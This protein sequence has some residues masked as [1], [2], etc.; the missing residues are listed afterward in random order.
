MTSNRSSSKFID[1]GMIFGY[2]RRTVWLP[3]LIFLSLFFAMP[4]AL[5]LKIQTSVV[6]ITTQWNALTIYAFE[7]NNALVKFIFV[8]AA[9]VCG[10]VIFSFIHSQKKVDFYH[11]LPISRSKLFVNNYLAGIFNLLLPYLLAVILSLVVLAGNG[12]LSYLDWGIFFA[13]IGIHLLGYLAI[14]SFVVLAAVITGNVVVN[15]LVAG[16]FLG[17]GPLFIGLYTWLMNT[18]YENFYGALFDTEKLLTYVSPLLRYVM[19]DNYQYALDWADALSL[20]VF[21]A[22]AF[23]LSLFLYK[24]RSSEKAGSAIA[25]KWVKPILKYPVIAICAVGF[26]LMLYEVSNTDEGH[27]WLYFGFVCGGVISSRIIELFYAFDFKAIKK[28]WVS[29]AVFAVVFAC[30]MAV[31]VADLTKYDA[32]QP[33]AEQVNKIELDLEYFNKFAENRSYN[34]NYRYYNDDNRNRLIAFTEEADIAKVLALTAKAVQMTEDPEADVYHDYMDYNWGNIYRGSNTSIGVIYTLENGN[35]VKRYYSYRPTDLLMDEISQVVDTNAYKT[36]IYSDFNKNIEDIVIGDIIAFEGSSSE[37]NFNLES[38][39][40]I[41][42]Q[43]LYNTYKE[44]LLALDSNV[45][46]TT[47]PIGTVEIMVLLSPDHPMI[48]GRNIVLEKG[49]S[50]TYSVYYPIYPSFKNTL[51]EL[52]AL[53][54]DLQVFEANAENVVSVDI[55]DSTVY[56]EA[57]LEKQKALDAQGMAGPMATG[58]DKAIGAEVKTIKDKAEIAKIL[59]ESYTEKAYE[60]NSFILP[61]NNISINVNYIS[62]YS[63]YGATSRYFPVKD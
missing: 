14:Y 36:Q 29:L 61:N 31:P 24:K 10:L 32:Y 18:F 54:L 51:K 46:K 44:E 35:K 6:G 27:F 4:V 62:D 30:I 8:V 11:S 47:M 37:N 60:Y 38:L 42:R 15:F 52:Q 3:T 45:M 39:N 1:F 50:F 57:M 16:I 63:D 25:F 56:N 9:I 53:G 40:L 55:T 12:I 7:P 43:K 2:V 19:I 23:V 21:A 22:V 34:F 49:Q 20:F 13:G 5:A 33:K 28:N 48:K 58:E 17:I 26:G 59:K 41:A